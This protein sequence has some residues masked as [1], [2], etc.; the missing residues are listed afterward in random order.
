M[1]RRAEISQLFMRLAAEPLLERRNQARLSDAR[2]AG[3]QHKLTFTL[4]C[5]APT[6][7]QQLELLVTPD[8]RR[9]RPGMHRLEAALDGSLSHH[10][11][12]RDRFGEAFQRDQPEIPIVK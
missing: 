7:Q 1:V 5:L 12:G 10:L 2:F 8:E 4:F 9:H 6:P 11:P 3:E